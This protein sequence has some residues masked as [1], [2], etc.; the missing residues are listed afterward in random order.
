MDPAKVAYLDAVDYFKT[1][2]TKDEWKKSWVDTTSSLEDVEVALSTARSKYESSK[3]SRARVWLAKFSS[4][5]MYY[6]T[7]LGK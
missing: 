6:S 7:I 3:Q 1:T 4:R 5:V 2:L